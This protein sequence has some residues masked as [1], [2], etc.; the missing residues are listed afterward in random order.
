MPIIFGTGHLSAKFPLNA[1][2]TRFT[3]RSHNNVKKFMTSLPKLFLFL[4]RKSNSIVFASLT[5]AFGLW[6]LLIKLQTFRKSPLLGGGWGWVI[7]KSNSSYFFVSTFSFWKKKLERKV[8]KKKFH[9]K[10]KK[11]NFFLRVREYQAILL[12]WKRRLKD[13]KCSNLH[14][15]RISV[16]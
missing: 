8:W 4:R 15:S 12:G 14:Y 3:L 13:Q 11:R 6:F 10:E 2:S 9:Q 5:N 1:H 16:V 7:K